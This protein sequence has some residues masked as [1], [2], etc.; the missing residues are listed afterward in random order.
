MSYN[1]NEVIRRGTGSRAR[2]RMAGLLRA[3]FWG[4]YV[5]GKIIDLIK[6]IS[7]FFGE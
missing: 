2:K 4:V 5:V 1:T 6:W 3:V 7:Q